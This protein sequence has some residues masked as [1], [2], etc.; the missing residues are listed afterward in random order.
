M[1]I[2]FIGKGGVGKT[3]VSSALALELSKSGKTAI[4]SSDFMS[5][6]RHIFP[7][8]PK[9]L[10]VT[11]M[12]E[13]EVAA[14]WIKR[15]GKD[16]NTV[17]QQFFK[18]DSWIID[19]IAESPGVAEEFMISNILDLDD[20]GKYDFVVWDTAASSST[21][22]LLMLEK[23]F[24]EHLDR[25]VM[26][27]LKLRDRF[28][29]EK[30]L[31]L[32]DEWKALAR[33]AWEKLEETSFFLVT[34]NDELSLIQA[35]EIEEDFNKMNLKI[36]GRICNRCSKVAGDGYALKVP[37]YEGSAREIVEKI[38]SGLK[39]SFIDFAKRSIEE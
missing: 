6:L 19:H 14:A 25:D 18:V 28:H 16:V 2:A 32:L 29:T 11:E 24:Y 27:F 36:Q 7:D 8:E 13:K 31:K 34:T 38:A 21:M 3:T 23:E 30:V 20:S 15:Y 4:V 22:H 12:K 5:S 39:S 37:E 33:K 26:I 10:S 1:L 9:S 17:L 35:D